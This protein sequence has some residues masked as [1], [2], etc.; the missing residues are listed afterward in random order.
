LLSPKDEPQRDSEPRKPTRLPGTYYALVKPGGKQF[1]QS[2][3][4]KDRA[5]AKRDGQENSSSHI[6]KRLKEKPAIVI[7]TKVQF[8][9]LAATMRQLDIRAQR[10]A[11]LTELLALS[12][13]RLG[14][15]T[16]IRWSD[17]DFG[18]GERS[19]TTV[20]VSPGCEIP[21]RSR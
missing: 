19:L 13:M 4:T 3:K 18:R 5:L 16:S 9:I 11:H 6:S 7:P 12:G 10:G 2:L 15:A 21:M 1:R 8:R 17:V 14:E 20:R